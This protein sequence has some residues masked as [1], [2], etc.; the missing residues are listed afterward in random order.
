MLCVWIELR[1]SPRRTKENWQ[2]IRSRRVSVTFF[3]WLND[4]CLWYI[5]NWKK[6]LFLSEIIALISGTRPIARVIVWF[7]WKKRERFI[8][9]IY[10]LNKARRITR[11]PITY[12]SGYLIEL[13]RIS[14]TTKLHDGIKN[15]GDNRIS[16]YIYFFV[17]HS[18]RRAVDMS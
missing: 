15:D 17:Q 1:F 12:I 11:P 5:H 8:P 4:I 16:D 9:F 6:W 18:R 10:W 7:Q 13:E 2:V 14:E 3:I